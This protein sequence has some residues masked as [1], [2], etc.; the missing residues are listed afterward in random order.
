MVINFDVPNE[1]E[2]YIHRIGRT[3]RAGAHGKA[4]MFVSPLEK[5]LFEKIQNT[6]KITIKTSD[7]KSIRDDKRVYSELRLDRSTDKPGARRMG[8]TARGH[9]PGR[10]VRSKHSARGM[11]PRHE[12]GARR[13]HG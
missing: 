9:N 8:K 11:S 6:Q 3:G 2:S 12:S 10:P 5:P 13:P 1:P 7:Y 4:I